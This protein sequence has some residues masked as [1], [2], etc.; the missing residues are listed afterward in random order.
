MYLVDT[1]VW[2]EYLLNQVRAGDAKQF[3][4]A[5]D[6]SVLFISDFSLHSTAVIL[7]RN[8]QLAAFDQFI[9]DLFVRGRMSALTVA[10]ADTR[11]VTAA[12]RSQ[13]FDF[14]DAYQYVI[15][16]R[17]GLVL[18]SFDADF[19]R[20]DLRRQTPAQILAARV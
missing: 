5:F 6:T 15:A 7:G 12:M 8:R 18:V 9:E 10:A 3:L 1:N 2:L 17:D 19:D 13:R 20:T 11:T 14:D 16:K 4:A